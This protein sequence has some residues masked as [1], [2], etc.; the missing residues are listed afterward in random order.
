MDI[1]EIEA[2]DDIEEVKELLKNQLNSNED[3]SSV[4]ETQNKRISEL[5]EQLNITNKTF[6]ETQAKLKEMMSD[7]GV[8]GDKEQ[9]GAPSD[10]SNSSSEDDTQMSFDFGD[11]RPAEPKS[12]D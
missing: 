12:A 5:E 11:S 7:S 1:E 9:S 6:E 4:I 10:I 2:L 8:E 3:N